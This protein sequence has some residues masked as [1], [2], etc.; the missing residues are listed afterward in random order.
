MKQNINSYKYIGIFYFDLTNQI[1][2]HA[3]HALNDWEEILRDK[4]LNLLL[5]SIT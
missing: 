3:S 2:S 5:I 4:I 1:S